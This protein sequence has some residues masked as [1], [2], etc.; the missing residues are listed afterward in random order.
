MKMLRKIP[1]FLRGQAFL[2]NFLLELHIQNTRE[3]DL[4]TARKNSFQNRGMEGL[5]EVIR[6]AFFHDRRLENLSCTVKY[7]LKEER[8]AVC[9]VSKN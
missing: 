9:M 7:R 4:G 2:Q 8:I 6:G 5:M 1:V 3:I